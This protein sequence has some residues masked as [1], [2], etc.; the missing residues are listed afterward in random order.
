MGNNNGLYLD[1]LLSRWVEYFNGNLAFPYNYSNIN[2]VINPDTDNLASTVTNVVSEGDN[3][4][5]YTITLA[6][7]NPGPI[8]ID[9]IDFNY[10]YV[11]TIG[12]DIVNGDGESNVYFG[13]ATGDDDITI[14]S[15]RD[16]TLDAA[17]DVYISGGNEFQLTLVNQDNMNGSEGIEIR[18]ETTSGSKTWTFRFD[19]YMNGLQPERYYKLLFK[20]VLITGGTVISDDNYYFKVIR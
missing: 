8:T 15:G 17:D 3:P 13:M 20:T 4:E 9:D 18:T 1:D 12:L 11:N 19:V 16:I 5:L 2:L 6:T 14:R 10:T 7:T